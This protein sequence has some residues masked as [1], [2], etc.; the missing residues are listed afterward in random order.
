MTERAIAGNRFG[1]GL[2][3]S[4]AM[5]R[6]PAEWLRGQMRSFQPRPPELA[7]APSRAEV[8]GTLS[9]YLEEVR[10]MRPDGATMIREPAETQDPVKAARRFAART[11][12]DHYARAVGARFAAA[13]A[14]DAPFIERLVHF[15]SNHFAVSAD[16]LT[17]VGLSGLLEF[18]AI[19]PHVLGSFADMLLA[20]EQHPAMLLYLDQA[21]SIG[22]GSLAGTRIAA[23]GRRQAGLNENLAREI[24]E[25]HTLGV[26]TGYSQTDVTELARALTGWTVSGMTRGPIARAIGVDG[27][28]GAFVFAPVVHE[29]GARK[30]LSRRYSQNGEAQARAIL[31]DLAV[32]PATA[33]HIA[34]KL[35]RH[36]SADDPPAALVTRLEQRFLETGGKLPALYEVLI[37]ARECWA[38]VS[39]KFKAPWDWSVSAFRALGLA[40]VDD[41]VAVNLF[42]QLGQPVWRP[43]SPAGYDDIAASWAGPD[44]LFRRVEVADR[45]ARRAAPGLDLRQISDAVLGKP[46][47]ATT[48]AISRAESPVQGLSLMLVS[49][50]FLR[51]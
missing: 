2:R 11:G 51:R 6:T 30:V 41:L 9:D 16:K 37:E 43:K 32:H 28:P 50:E 42:T 46:T 45:L 15:W 27:K 22:P 8:A 10:G 5:P 1:L 3:P 31:T 26:R 36:F 19:R 13:I 7:N 34:I 40:R 47:D 44:A 25:L 38:P 14:T 21:Q 39:T 35:A 20:V 33:R 18:E 4:D 48:K 17:V 24:L 23:R 12:R 29:P 49:P